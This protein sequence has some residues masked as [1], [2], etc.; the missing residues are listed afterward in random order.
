MI[1]LV[2]IGALVVVFILACFAGL[3][4]SIWESF[5]D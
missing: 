5:D 3:I 1:R 2:L 4:M